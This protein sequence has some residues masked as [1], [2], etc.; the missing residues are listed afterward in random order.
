MVINTE[1]GCL[2]DRTEVLP[3]KPFDDEINEK[4]AGPGAQMF[5]K[6]VSRLYLVE[7]LLLALLKLLRDGAFEMVFDEQSQLL[8]R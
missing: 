2:D 6:R 4:P 8:R 5:E 7:I 3:R 1:W